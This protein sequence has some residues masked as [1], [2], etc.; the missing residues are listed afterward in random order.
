MRKEK[1]L[2]D[3]DGTAGFDRADG[4][5]WH[6]HNLTKDERGLSVCILSQQEFCV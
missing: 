3:S 1:G 5:V 6:V 2:F 4:E